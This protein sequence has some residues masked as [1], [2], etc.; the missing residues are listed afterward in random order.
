VDSYK[1]QSI[2]VLENPEDEFPWLKIELLA[3][4]HKLPVDWIRKG[5]EA[6]FQLGIS[7][8]FFIDK[9]VLKIK[10]MEKNLELIEVFKDLGGRH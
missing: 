4:K 9:Y 7:P 3:A 1:A 5:F 2:K 8:D 6:S 10:G